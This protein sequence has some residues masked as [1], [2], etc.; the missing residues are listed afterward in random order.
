MKEKYVLLGANIVIISEL[1]ALG[2]I[3]FGSPSV[4]GV[5]AS[6][7]ILGL[8]ILVFGATFKEPLTEALREY[9]SSAEVTLT[10]LAEDMGLVPEWVATACL[11]SEGRALYVVSRAPIDC[12]EVVPGVGLSPSSPYIGMVVHTVVPRAAGGVVERL[13]SA[14]NHLSLS[15]RVVV[16]V[17]GEEATI[18]FLGVR[19]EAA[20]SLRYPF[21][22]M[23]VLTLAHAA[24]AVGS[25]VVLVREDLTGDTYVA[26]VRIG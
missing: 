8:V 16:K 22:M 12:S 3:F 15:S 24:S 10:R 5:S 1:F 19:R 6:T 20:D 14:M 4:L 25:R 26:V 21:G 17:R 23:R 13:L 2:A 18:E 11:V 7:L 9:R